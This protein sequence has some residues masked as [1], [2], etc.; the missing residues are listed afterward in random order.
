MSSKND[1]QIGPLIQQFLREQGLETPLNE[2]R[3]VQA[4]PEVA[5]KVIEKYTGQV[6]VKNRILNVQIRSASLKHNLSMGR[7][8]L[9]KKLND[10]VGADVI[11]DIRFY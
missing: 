7:A 5:G 1:F 3:I 10:F 9:T 4:W 6:F 2:Y 8:I 11:S